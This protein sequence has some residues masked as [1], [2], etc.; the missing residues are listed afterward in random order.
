MC[1]RER[2]V[3]KRSDKQITAALRRKARARVRSP[4]GK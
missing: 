4:L 2:L 3:L 1:K